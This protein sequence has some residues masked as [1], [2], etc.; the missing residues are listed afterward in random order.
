MNKL[1]ASLLAL[2]STLA[3]R[4]DEGFIVG[5]TVSSGVLYSEQEHEAISMNR[6]IID[7][8][9]FLQT[10]TKSFKP[11]PIA[12]YNVLFEFENNSANYYQVDCGF[13]IQIFFTHFDPTYRASITEFLT[14]VFPDLFD[15][16]GSRENI[17]R[18][19]QA[20][21]ENRMFIRRFINVNQLYMVHTGVNIFQ[22]GL[23][24]PVD[25]VMVEFRLV[26]DGRGNKNS[27]LSMQM[28]LLHKLKFTPRQK[29]NVVVKYYT[30]AF[31][32]GYDGYNFYAPYVLGTGATWKGEIQE[33]YVL[34]RPHES[35]LALPYYLDWAG[36]DYD[37]DKR[38]TIIQGHEPERF[39]KIGFF[40]VLNDNCGCSK[41]KGLFETLHMPSALKN[42][43]ASSTLSNT[44]IIQGACF[45]AAMGTSISKWIPDFDMGY[46]DNLIVA[47]EIIEQDSTIA[48][49]LHALAENHCSGDEAVVELKGAYHPLW[50][51]DISTDTISLLGIGQRSQFGEGTAWCEGVRGTGVG[52]YL[53]FE[54]TQPAVA[55]SLNPGLQKSLEAFKET[56]RPKAIE[57]QDANKR[58][59]RLLPFW[60]FMTSTSF[61]LEL[62]PGKYRLLIKETY[63]GT[64]QSNTC[65]S[66]VML[67]FT[68]DDPWLNE[69]YTEL[70]ETK[71]VIED[72]GE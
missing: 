46:N 25:R 62:A 14:E 1:T 27:V 43:S 41:D 61:D 3:L 45:R 6:E 42:V 10:H 36:Y 37:Y 18:N 4:A 32:M 24:V 55:I 7:F 23:E 63:P 40:G 65:I 11:A 31:N 48:Q 17:I 28:H 44:S 8:K 64:S 67:K 12:T 50:A 51:F 47:G 26:D 34:N 5:A 20:V 15:M 39:E 70:K 16:S 68:L 53:D 72:E 33:I 9:G 58:R 21:F 2:V 22:D 38:L 69:A 66:N 13:P 59:V 54:I 56:S 52:Q 19:M 60:D 57:L 29:S 71:V 30:P 35:S 49:N